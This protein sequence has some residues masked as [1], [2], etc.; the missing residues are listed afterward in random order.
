MQAPSD[1]SDEAGSVCGMCKQTRCI[2]GECGSSDEGEDSEDFMET[3]AARLEAFV[4]HLAQ[5]QSFGFT[6]Q[7]VRTA[8]T[9][10][11]PEGVQ[12]V[13]EWLVRSGEKPNTETATTMLSQHLPEGECRDYGITSIVHRY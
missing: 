11:G 6:E 4:Q 5:A 1:Y 13:V 8:V 2:F 10:V 3:H 9:T 7:A 12:S